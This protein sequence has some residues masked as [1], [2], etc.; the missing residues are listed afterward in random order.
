MEDNGRRSNV[1][2]KAKLKV[3]FKDTSAFISEYTHNI[4]KGGL[5]VRT[6]KPCEK[7]SFVQVILIMPETENEV[8]AVG[9]VIHVIT[10]GQATDSQP[11]G[12]GIELKEI[13]QADQKLI[14]D[15]IRDKL[16]SDA[17]KESLG[18]REH[19]RYETKIRVRFGS[20]EALA[21]EYT[22]NISHGGIYIRTKSP[23]KLREKL[24][25]ILTHP[26]TGAEMELEGEVV[27]VVSEDESYRTGQ[28]AGMGIRFL[29]MG[30]DT[31]AQI[32]AFINSESVTRNKRVEF[33]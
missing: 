29:T 2:V 7:N 24:I 16:K 27:R 6:G 26:D 33:E 18:R 19:Q 31:K 10:P 21:E 11:S 20:R 5:F 14:E 4:S 1:R 8:S 15:F 30:H 22:H 13:S 32:T 3:R 17:E 9:E 28:P 25:I 12:M 23:K